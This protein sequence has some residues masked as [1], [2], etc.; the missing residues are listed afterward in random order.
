VNRSPIPRVLSTL[1]RHRVKALLMGGQACILYGAAEFSRDVDLAVAV[2]PGNLARL[3]AALAALG[4]EPV[5]FPPL[6]AESLS[7]G[8]ACHFRCRAPGLE[9]VRVDVIAVMRGV[10]PFP[11]LWRRRERVRLPGIGTV[12]VMAVTD[13]VQAK[14]TQRDKDWP[15]IRRLLEADVARSPRHASRA[16]I[17]FWLREGRTPAL[18]MEVAQRHPRIAAEEARRRPALRAARAGDL[19]AT[20]ETLR[21]EED[22]ERARDRRYW[23]P[24][25]AEL[26]R[27]RLGRSRF[28]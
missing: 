27:W 13:L 16:R 25:R 6:S 2:D 1:R 26:E 24:L 23:K 8:H 18:L 9:S 21:R 7:R 19:A 4:A 12:P 28:P 11:R 10:D 14:K 20:E 3:R 15:M 17:R 5:F 22:Q